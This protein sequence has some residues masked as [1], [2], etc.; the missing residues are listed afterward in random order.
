[1]TTFLKNAHVQNYPI[2]HKIAPK[3]MRLA[4]APANHLFLVKIVW[5]NKKIDIVT[6]LGGRFSV[7]PWQPTI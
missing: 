5:I 3:Y 6:S 7:P 4:Y 2:V 1:M